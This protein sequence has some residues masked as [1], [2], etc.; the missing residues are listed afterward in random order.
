MTVFAADGDVVGPDHPFAAI[1]LEAVTVR[2]RI[3]TEKIPT[4]KEF[5]IRRLLNGRARYHDFLALDEVSLT[6][7]RGEVFGIIGVN[8]AG[9]STLLKVVARVIKPTSGRVRVRGQVAALLELG[10]GFDSELTGR[11]NIYLNGA[12]LGRSRARIG[13]RIEQIVNFAG[14]REF[15]DA[16]LRTYSSGMVARLGFAAATDINPDILIVDEILSVGDKD[17]QRKSYDRMRALMERG[18]T[19]LLVSHD[20]SAIQALCQRAVWLENG[21][22]KAFGKAADVVW[23]YLRLPAPRQSPQTQLAG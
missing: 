13:E 6:F 14:V 10:A 16:P 12:L 15:I 5:A 17:F 7:R 18:T 22:V 20:M 2:Y 19:V 3:P 8:G 11:E 1:S 4:F 23:E 9:K 21:R